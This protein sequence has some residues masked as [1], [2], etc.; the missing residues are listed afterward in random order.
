MTKIKDI[1]SINSQAVLSNAIQ[2]SWYVDATKKAENNRLVSGYVFGNGIN[3]RIGNYIESSSLPV[4]EQIRDAFGNPQ[5]SNI[6][7]VVARYGHGKSH[8]ALVLANYFGLAPDS[9]VVGSIINHIE[10]CSDKATADQFRFFKAQ[11]TR[12]QLVVTLAGIDFQDLRQGFLQALRRALDLHDATRDFPIKSVSAKAAEWLKSLNAEAIEKADNFLSEKYNTDVDSLIAALDNFESGKELIVKD[13]SRI[14]NNGYAI[15]FGADANLKEIIEDTV[16]TLCTGADAPFHKM[17]ILFDE[18]GVYAGKW[19]LHPTASGGSAPQ[20]IFEACLN[21]QGK[22]CFVG[23]VQRELEKFVSEYPPEVQTEFKKWAGR[24]HNDAVYQLISNLEEVISKVIVKKPEWKR[25]IEDFSPR[26]LDE[27]TVARESIQHYNENWE[28]NHFYSTIT[29]DCFPLHPLTTGL[30]C[31]FEFAEGS[32]SIISAVDS[33]LKSAQENPINENSKLQWI[34]PIELVRVFEQAFAQ[35]KSRPFADYQD[36]LETALTADVEPVLLDVL[37]ALFLFKE[38]KMTKQNRY[39]HA[40]LLA[41]LAGYTVTETKDALDRLQK[42]FD[43]I[44]FSPQKR[45]YEFTD[46]V[47]GRK[48]VLDMAQKAII[49]KNA[50]SFVKL[51]EKLKAFETIEESSTFNP[52]DKNQAREFKADFAVEGDEWFLTP[53]YLD[54]K[55]LTIEE[56]KKLCKQTIDESEARGTV[57]YIIS[58]SGAE[59]DQARENAANIFRQLKEENYAHPFVFAVPS[60]PATHLEKQILIKDYIVNG[61]SQP[62]KVR[63]AESHRSAFEFTNKELNDELVAHLR[64]VDYIVP[65]ALSLKFGNRKKTLDEIADALFADAYKFRAPSNS[66]KLRPSATTGNTATALIARQL[67]VNDFN[68]ESFDTPKQT[69]IRQVLTEGINKWGIL[70]ANYKIRDP[71]DLR[72]MQAWSFLRNNVS[73]TEWTT[74]AGLISK[75]MQPPFGYDE[76]TATF[77]I[78]AWIGK[79][80]HELAF[81]DKR[82]TQ[83]VR[84]VGVL[85][86]NCVQANLKLPELQSNLNRAKDFIRFLRENVS[87]QNSRQII[88]KEAENYLEQLRTVSDVSEAE[89]LLEQREEIL[90]TLVSGDDLIP[91]I[92]EAWDNR[93]EYVDNSKRGELDLAK[94]RREAENTDDISSLLRTKNLLDIFGRQNGM[95]SNATF[96]NTLKFVSDKIESVANQQLQISLT[97]IESYDSTRN[98]LEKGLA[99]LRQT[100]RADLQNSFAAALEKLE[101]DYERLKARESE[102]PFITEINSIQTSGMPLRFYTDG[103]HRI[104]EILA[105]NPSERVEQHALSKQTQLTE[106]IKKL[107]DFAEKVTARATD[108]RD[109]NQAEELQREIHR[110]ENIYHETPEAENISETLSALTARISEMKKAYRLA[111]EEKE[112][113]RQRLQ[114]EKERE[115]KRRMEILLAQN[116]VQQFAEISDVEQRFD[117]LLN[118]FRAARQKGLSDEQKSHLSGLLN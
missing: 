116:V 22:I 33:M 99:G 102:Q 19:C 88:H 42:D 31:R 52:K 35:K 115:Q 48:I 85:P 79:H 25:V 109:V 16:D 50:D 65:Q 34:R 2:L 83:P 43:A 111:Q 74:F 9:L 55:R 21:K 66:D 37:K 112:K 23:F 77:L 82:K 113:E 106:Q 54:A 108:V 47:S 75:L 18:L 114:E 12:P 101:R 57:I 95:Q 59:L 53:R 71:K 86:Q 13:L 41:H 4:F 36:V 63:F 26:L 11:T 51:L 70:D 44:R 91:Q 10:T 93:K 8:F 1:V 49:G 69:I 29:R 90:Q 110:R 118:I 45:E 104:E 38:T 117:V 6:F 76:Y 28:A 81:K 84:S 62:D 64:S 68:F 17:L 94:F 56:V 96:V 107:R 24:M 89:E 87:V 73:K 15:D 27:S 105:E 97:R 30:L 92:N 46:S 32:R 80:K 3:K 72:V 100:D 60:D 14:L 78:A 103:L 5:A 7:T 39:E 98:K 40:E 58:G 61:M 67:I 20:E